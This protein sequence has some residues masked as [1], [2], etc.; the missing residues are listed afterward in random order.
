VFENSH[1]IFNKRYIAKSARLYLHCL[2]G[3]ILLTSLLSKPVLSEQTKPMV[4]VAATTSRNL[5]QTSISAN[6]GD[7]QLLLLG[8]IINNRVVIE[9][10]RVRGKEDG[11]KAID[12]DNWLIPIDD[13]RKPLKLQ[14]FDLSDGSIEV[15]APTIKGRYRPLNF[16]T[17]QQLGTVISLADL[18]AITGKS[19]SF[20]LNKYALV[21]ELAEEQQSFVRSSINDTDTLTKDLPVNTPPQITLSAIEQKVNVN[22]GENRD[23][24]IGGEFRAIGNFYDTSWYFRANQQ[25]LNRPETWRITE[26]SIIRQQPQSDLIVGSQIP[27]WR[28]RGNQGTYWGLTSINRQ[29]FVPPRQNSGGEFLVTDRLQSRRIGRTISGQAPPGAIVRLVKGGTLNP[30][31]EVLVDTSGIFRFDNVVIAGSSQEFFGQDYRLLIYPK[32]ALSTNPEIRTPQ[33]TTTP[34]QLPPGASAWVVTAGGNL[35]PRNIL[36]DFEGFQGG[37]L[38]RQGISESL[39]IG[40]GAAHDQGVLGI[41]EIFWQPN[42]VPLEVAFFAAA[43]NST[44]FVG[45]ASYRPNQDIFVN[46]NTDN[47]STRLDARW[48]LT[49]GFSVAANY[50]TLRG[51]SAGG[52]YLSSSPNSSTFIKGSIDDQARIKV[53]ANQRFNRWQA[54]FQGNESNLVGQLAYK[55]TDAP[56]SDSGHLLSAGYQINQ[57]NTV[58]KIADNSS[59]LTNIIW[60][61]NSTERTSDG[62]YT[63]QS[64]LGYGWNNFGSGIFAGVDIALI[65]GWRL[66]GNYRG[67]SASA[68]QSDFSVALTTTIQI[69]GRIRGNDRS[70]DDL[71]SFGRVEIK[72]F[73]DTNQN[74][75]Q[76]PGE[77]NYWDSLL[78]K[79]NQVDLSHYRNQVID[80]VATASLLP[81]SYLVEVDPSGY[82][83]SYRSGI[84]PLRVDV[85]PSST[86]RIAIPLTPSYVIEGTLQD[87]KGN[88]LVDTRV[89]IISIDNQLKV[90]SVTDNTGNFYLE[91]LGIGT[92]KFK[93]GTYSISPDNLKIDTTTK[94]NQKIILRATN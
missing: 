8:V 94:P 29:G 19:I 39:T 52:E 30:L 5:G 84:Q 25:A 77:K 46:A 26:A 89:E 33:F 56:N 53:F 11:E 55:L 12:F 16:I 44:N 2:V 40:I 73:F 18:K 9:S 69:D 62:S 60:R 75:K 27:F 68:N 36:G 6:P 82:P 66:R 41:G 22:G 81:G 47:T 80:S 35:I 48:R 58:N 34:G 42:N 90:D 64:E 85:L 49:P 10:L 24:N 45:R 74:G 57:S 43:G 59:S 76:D 38:Y 54:N 21:L 91:G 70:L 61:F 17:D 32:A 4:S 15:A 31:D 71:R 51:I 28:R 83:P 67:I 92:Y 78:I 13:L 93:V 3:Y 72:P 63:W 20:N 86:N 14:I 7:S 50:D 88:P 1:Q 23:T 65:P 79:V 37:A 87:Q